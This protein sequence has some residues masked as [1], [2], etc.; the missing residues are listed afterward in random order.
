RLFAEERASG[1]L[2]M[3][4][5]APLRDWQ[6]VLSKFVAC[7]G[8][9]AVMWLPTLVY[10]PV[11]LDLSVEWGGAWTPFSVVLTAGVAAVALGLLLALL[12]GE[13]A[14]R[15][16]SLVL[17]LA[18]LAAAAAG[19]RAHHALDSEHLLTVEAGIDP[20]PVLSS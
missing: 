19:G 3:L 6:I 12:P 5:T 18:G 13:A 4:L 8:F 9:Y 11:L 2:E 1:T 14:P 15:G 7:F 16:L 20:N 10:L 17:V